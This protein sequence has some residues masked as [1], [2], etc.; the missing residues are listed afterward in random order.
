MI[1]Y[2]LRRL[3][4]GILVLWVLLSTLFFIL[5]FLPGGP[6]DTD[7]KLPPEVLQ[8]LRVKYHLN[9]PLW[10]QYTIYLKNVAL[11]L[12]LGPSLK[13]PDRSVN[14]MLMSSFPISFQLGVL[15]FIISYLIG[16]PFG[17]LA[18]YRHNT[19]VDRFLMI[20]AISGV[21]LPSFLTGSLLILLFSKILSLLP[22]ARWDGWQHMILPAITLGLRPAAILARLM[23]GSALE[24]LKADY[25]RTA[26]AKGLSE[27]DILFK[28]VLK[29]AFLPILTL[30]G[31]LLASIITGSFI[32]EFI[33]AIPGMADYFVDAVFNRDY[34]LIIGATLLYAVLLVLANILV[35]VLYTVLD[36]RIVLV[37]GE[38]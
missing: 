24:I 22:A 20:S 38:K 5:R 32:V 12:D 17:L 33:F 8:N 37:R 27:V 31:P 23:R 30:S 26:R 34:T 9:L 36:S 15:A 3:L 21:S 28:H 1:S 2:L 29:N 13:N 19:S 14:E 6:F 18:A 25:I 4:Y 7:K 35:D 16:I 11:H 10:Q